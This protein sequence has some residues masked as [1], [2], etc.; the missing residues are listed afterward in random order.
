MA[1][2]AEERAPHLARKKRIFNRDKFHWKRLNRYCCCCYCL[3]ACA[4]TNAIVHSYTELKYSYR[5]TVN[6][7]LAI[8]D[9]GQKQELSWTNRLIR[10]RV[11]WWSQANGS[12]GVV[13]FSG[14]KW[15][16]I[17]TIWM[18]ILSSEI[19][20]HLGTGPSLY[21][22]HSFHPHTTLQSCCCL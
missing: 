16:E 1:T 4:C 12:R 9:W 18:N 14:E 19:D 6:V 15:N 5:T 10:D 3:H 11:T 22:P 8:H 7:A 20:G 2:T 17:L 13:I 21:L